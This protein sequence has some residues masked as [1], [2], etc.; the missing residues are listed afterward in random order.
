MILISGVLGVRNQAC[1]VLLMNMLNLIY[2]VAVGAQ[3]G[4]CAIVGNKIGQAK[5]KET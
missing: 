3:F 1:M 5:L 4:V 2:M